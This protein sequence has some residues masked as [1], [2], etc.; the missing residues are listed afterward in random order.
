MSK[1]HK[2][3]PK[4]HQLKRQERR[5]KLWQAQQPEPTTYPEPPVAPW[6]VLG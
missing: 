6:K 3:E 2:Q 5:R 4:P 1:T